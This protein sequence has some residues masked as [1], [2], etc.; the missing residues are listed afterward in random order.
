[1]KRVKCT[2][3][4]ADHAP[5]LILIIPAASAPLI[6]L[7]RTERG[8]HYANV[9]AALH[10]AISL[11]EQVQ[12]DPALFRARAR[13]ESTAGEFR[14]QL[15]NLTSPRFLRMMAGVPDDEAIAELQRCWQIIDGTT[16]E[17][18]T[19]LAELTG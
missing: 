1:M 14:E 7:M 6:P 11:A 2:I 17:L 4:F 10:N 8:Q 3:R 15:E 13:A 5:P 19:F 18:R 12:R 16:K 9:A